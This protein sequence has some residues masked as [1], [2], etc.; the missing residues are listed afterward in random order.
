MIKK[1]NIKNIEKKTVFVSTMT[2]NWKNWKNYERIHGKA[3]INVTMNQTRM[4]KN[5]FYKCMMG[6]T[7]KT[8][9]IPISEGSVISAKLL[10]TLNSFIENG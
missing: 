6:S 1:C 7:V 10:Q 5:M 8:L 4:D 2:R 9:Q 3:R